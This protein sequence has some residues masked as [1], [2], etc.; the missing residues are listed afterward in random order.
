[1]YKQSSINQCL[2]SLVTF[3]IVLDFS[4]KPQAGPDHHLKTTKIAGFLIY[5]NVFEQNS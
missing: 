3:K 4:D 1:M 5:S 2:Y